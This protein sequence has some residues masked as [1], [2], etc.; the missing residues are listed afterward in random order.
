MTMVDIRMLD[1]G[2][3]PIAKGTRQALSVPVSSDGILDR[4]SARRILIHGVL[5]F[6]TN[7]NGPQVG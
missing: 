3:A 6:G 2:Y 7:T 4:G 5:P 1:V